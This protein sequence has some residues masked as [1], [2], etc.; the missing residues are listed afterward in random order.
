MEVIYG[1][2]PHCQLTVFPL[3]A[4]V[5]LDCLC[6]LCKYD[7]KVDGQRKGWGA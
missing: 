3:S 7:G 1:M 2:K 4:I 5:V 6:R